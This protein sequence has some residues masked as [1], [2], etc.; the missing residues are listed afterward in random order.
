MF[1]FTF[2]TLPIEFCNFDPFIS[3]ATQYFVKMK[4]YL[5]VKIKIYKIR[6]ACKKQ[7]GPLLIPINECIEEKQK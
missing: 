3:K 6:L 2:H 5:V 7:G 4:K 1:R